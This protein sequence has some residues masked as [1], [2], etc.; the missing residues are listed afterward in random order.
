MSDTN[1]PTAQKI[2]RKCLAVISSINPKWAVNAGLQIF[3]TPLSRRKKNHYLPDDMVKEEVVLKG[4]RVHL[5]RYG[6][7]SK[8]ILLVHG[9]EGAASDFSQFFKPLK[10]QNFEIWT[11]DLPG[12]GESAFSQLN[13]LIASDLLIELND[14]KGPF[15]ALVGH[16]FGGFSLGLASTKRAELSNLPLITIGAPTRL[17]RILEEYAK[18]V[19]FN[20]DQLDYM[21]NKIER[22]FKIKIND[23]EQGKFLK[24]HKAPILIVHDK[25]DEMVPY[26]RLEDIKEQTTAPEFHITDGLGHTRILRNRK[27]VDKIVSFISDHL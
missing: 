27:V 20:D 19:D 8:K 4:K 12:H 10:E 16:S 11:L 5:Y 15:L 22:D 6:Q 24:N 7:S 17:H 25:Q 23:F 14:L 21:F 2:V 1:I 18:F 3:S 26:S 13:V 9:W